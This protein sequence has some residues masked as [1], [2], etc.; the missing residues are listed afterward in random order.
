MKNTLLSFAI[1][2][3]AGLFG[4]LI[5]VG[6]GIIMIPLMVH[7]LKLSQ[8][9]AHGTS[10]M[11][12][13]FTGFGGALI[14]GLHGQISYLAAGLL[15]LTAI[16]T[17]R[18]G[19]RY[20]NV[21]SGWKL[22]KIFGGFLI[23]CALIL[24]AKPYLPAAG[25]P[26]PVYV[27]ILVFAAAGLATGFLSGLMGVGGGMI[28]IPAMVLFAG[29]G[30][31]VAQGTALAVMIPVGLTGAFAHSQMGNVVKRH[32]PGLLCGIFLGSILGGNLANLIPDM[33]LRATFIIAT[34]FLGIRYLRT[35]AAAAGA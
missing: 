27:N 20:A 34:A 22:R 9:Q 1:G 26:H 35:K 12:L 24:A 28:M 23:A 7:I 19:A 18:A 31:H 13:V 21:L 2:L 33:P 25:G 32:L 30:Q 4:G 29:F 15:A 3:S 17:A 8:H 6:G 14:Y 16:P 10:L 5:G 11:A